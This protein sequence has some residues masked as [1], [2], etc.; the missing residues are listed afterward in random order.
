MGNYPAKRNRGK[1]YPAKRN[2]NK[3]RNRNSNQLPQIFSSNLVSNQNFGRMASEHRGY[4]MREVI[5][6]DKY[7]NEK[8]FREKQFMVAGQHPGNMMIDD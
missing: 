6:K 1:R 4:V 2:H 5:I 3:P 8:I 7:G